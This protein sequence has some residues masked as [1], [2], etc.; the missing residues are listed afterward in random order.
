MA[1]E[2]KNIEY[3]IETFKQK[4][5]VILQN[6]PEKGKANVAK[7]LEAAKKHSWQNKAKQLEVLI[8]KI[9]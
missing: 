4:I 1:V 2:L 7:S 8:E 5:E 9:Q 3:S 6:W